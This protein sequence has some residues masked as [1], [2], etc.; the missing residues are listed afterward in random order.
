LEVS[1]KTR[2]KK[3]YRW[4]LVDLAIVVILFIL[5]LYRPNRYDPAKGAYDRQVSQYLTHEL[6]PQLYNGAQLQEPFDLVVTEEGIND[7]VARA[8][9]PRE[10]EG[11]RF[12]S[13]AVVFVPEGIVLMGTAAVRGLELVVTIVVEPVLDER[14]LLNLR[15][16]KVK[17]GAM[18][19]TLLARVM[20][21]RMYAQEIG[22]ED[23]AVEDLRAQIAASLL[24]D[25]PF[26]PVFKIKNKKVRV[27]KI[28]IMQNKLSLHLLP[29]FD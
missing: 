5:L 29:V 28:T 11:I 20:A 14:G 27:N 22:E 26:E 8:A 24:N 21:K 25:E 10:S 3:V 9:W 19:V 4:L 6:L 17:I 13:P 7:I 12:S 23:V 2:F 15:V 18:N 16:T 1:K